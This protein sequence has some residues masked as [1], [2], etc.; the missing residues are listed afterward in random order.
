M[1][2]SFFRK[3]VI[4]LVIL[5]NSIICKADPVDTLSVPIVLPSE[6]DDLPIIIRDPYQRNLY[7]VFDA[8]D[9]SVCFHN[10]SDII[11]VR[12]RIYRNGNLVISDD[13]PTPIDN[14]LFYNVS[15]YGSGAY[16]VMLCTD[17]TVYI[18]YFN[19]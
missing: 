2:K 10:L 8:L 12:I 17:T 14:I 11:F 15:S 3:L 19:Y 5:A 1:R 6:D 9:G 7:G 16:T 18:G 4:L 13:M